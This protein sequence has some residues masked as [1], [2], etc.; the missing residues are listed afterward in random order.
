MAINVELLPKKNH[1][2]KKLEKKPIVTDESEDCLLY[3]SDAA[4]E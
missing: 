1:R 3:T 4:D 2:S